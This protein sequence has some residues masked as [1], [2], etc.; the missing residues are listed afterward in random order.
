MPYQRWTL[1]IRINKLDSL[2]TDWI[3]CIFDFIFIIILLLLSFLFWRLNATFH[4]Y[5]RVK[6]KKKPRRAVK[7]KF[8]W[9]PIR[10]V[11]MNAK[12]ITHFKSFKRYSYQG[13][14]KWTAGI[15]SRVSTFTPKQTQYN[16][17]SNPNV[18]NHKS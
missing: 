2:W 11:D 16:E 3:G 9:L 18:H 12:N 4:N 8:I 14:P 17:R 13:I 15:I 5:G 6:D 1:S 7:R 10:Q